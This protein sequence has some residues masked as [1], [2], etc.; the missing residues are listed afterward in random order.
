MK[1]R[2]NEE[3]QLAILDFILTNTK[4]ADTGTIFEVLRFR[5]K[6]EVY[7]FVKVER[8]MKQLQ[9]TNKI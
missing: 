8:G 2:I 9:A 6:L 1:S 7:K 3:E 4:L 5:S